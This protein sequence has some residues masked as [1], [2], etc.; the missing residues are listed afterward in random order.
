MGL[1]LGAV[2]APASPNKKG[3]C[4]SVNWCGTLNSYPAPDQ[5]LNCKAGSPCAQPMGFMSA[6]KGA[7]RPESP[8]IEG[9]KLLFSRMGRQQAGINGLPLLAFQQDLRTGETGP[10]LTPWVIQKR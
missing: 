4:C 2:L 3:S 5:H 9:L 7:N 8:E 1:D 10:E 6:L